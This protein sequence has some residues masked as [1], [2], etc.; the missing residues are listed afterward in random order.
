M[1][2]VPHS[3]D[4]TKLARQDIGLAELPSP[5]EEHYDFPSIDG[6]K[7]FAKQVKTAELM[8]MQPHCYVLNGM[9]TGKT[10]AAIWAFDY[11]K[12]TGRAKSMLV[13]CPLSTMRFVWEREIFNTIPGL[14]TVVLTGD[15]ARRHKLLAEPADIYIVN[16]DGE[17]V[18]HEALMRRPDIDV[19]CF[20]EAAKYRTSN[21]HISRMARALTKGRKFVWG[22]TGSPTPSEPTDAFGLAHLINSANAPRSFVHFRQETMLQVNQFK[23]VPK[24]GAAE[25]VAK[26]LSPAVRYTLDEIV[27]L[28]PVYEREMQIEMGARQRATYQMLKEHASALLREGTITAVNGGVV[29]AA[30]DFNSIGGSTA[31][32]AKLMNWTTATASRP[33]S[34]S[35]RATSTCCALTPRSSSFHPS[36]APRK[37]LRG[38]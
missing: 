11:L 35:S 31:T 30:G 33:C 25:T 26:I 37:E 4:E 38:R 36:S 10:K 9:G 3:P 28:P 23:W 21:T 6:K 14:K 16:H 18:V 27:E 5:I 1:I 34:T 32:T 20:D 22:M 24:K 19:I 15:A 29:Y 8:T 13:T 12:K 7:A 17:K 2:V